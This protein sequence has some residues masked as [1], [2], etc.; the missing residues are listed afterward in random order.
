MDIIITEVLWV[1][2]TDHCIFFYISSKSPSLN[3]VD[4]IQMTLVFE[5][6]QSLY[7]SLYTTCVI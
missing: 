4:T 7:I 5:S 1:Q 3:K 2:S 6:I